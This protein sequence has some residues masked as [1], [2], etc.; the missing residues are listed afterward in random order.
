MNVIIPDSYYALPQ[1]ARQKHPDHYNAQA[2][3]TH[4]KI[5]EAY[6]WYRHGRKKLV[7]QI[8]ALELFSHSKQLNQTG[9]KLNMSQNEGVTVM[10]QR[11]RHLIE[12]KEK[13]LKDT[14]S[15]HLINIVLVRESLWT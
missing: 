5:Y 14:D 7:D 6:M 12:I 13:Q 11:I 1:Y 9:T 15:L 10:F 2:K 3:Q 4:K 8:Q